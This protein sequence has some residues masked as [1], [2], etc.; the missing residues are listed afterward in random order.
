MWFKKKKCLPLGPQKITKKGRAK[1]DG[2][3][4]CL[5]SP[6]WLTWN[7]E[8]TII[9]DTQSWQRSEWRCVH[10]IPPQH[11]YSIRAHVGLWKQWQRSLVR[12]AGPTL[13]AWLP[14]VSDCMSVPCCLLPY[15]LC[16]WSISLSP[17]SDLSSIFTSSLKQSLI[18][19]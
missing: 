15:V 18:P 6:S 10:V 14:L 5:G 16:T 12:A 11:L 2:K 4:A 7:S 8:L 1:S 17:H 19:V 9:L 3:R 13:V